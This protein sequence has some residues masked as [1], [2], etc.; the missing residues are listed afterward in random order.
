M[1]APLPFVYSATVIQFA[2]TDGPDYLWANRHEFIA[3]AGLIGDRE[4]AEAIAQLFAQF[5]RRVLL[6]PYGVDR[7]VLSTAGP[8]LPFP[9]G[10]AS[11]PFR[12]MGSVGVAGRALPLELAAFIRKRVAR[13]KNGKMFLRGVVSTD[14][15]RGEELVN[16]GG[17]SFVGNF[18]AAANQLLTG[19]Q[20]RNARLVV[21]PNALAATARD[22]LKLEAVN[23]RTL[24]YRTRRKT[25]LQAN[26]ISQLREFLE[27][28]AIVPP[29]SIPILLRAIRTLIGSSRPLLPPPA[30]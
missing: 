19:L 12:V 2:P 21:A 4:T 29:E 11:Y 23:V 13:G 22:V 5:H 30:P 24:Q 10:F 26:A 27:E 28:G 18:D 3:P 9:P 1:D 6:N 25:R 20:Q 16:A 15:I 8:D 17:F 7:V 14:M